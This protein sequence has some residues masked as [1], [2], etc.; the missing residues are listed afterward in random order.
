LPDGK[1]YEGY[2]DDANAFSL[3]FGIT[4]PGPKT[5]A[6]LDALQAGTPA[7]DETLSYFPEILFQYGRC[8][9]AYDLLLHLTSPEFA[10]HRNP[11]TVFVIAGTVATGLM[12]LTP[13]AQANRIDTLSRLPKSVESVGLSRVPILR[14][15]VAVRHRGG[16]E[17]SIT[18]QSGPAFYWKAAFALD[19]AATRRIFVDGHPVESALENRAGVRILASKAIPVEPS[20][21]R[22]AILG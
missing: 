9:A 18:N 4:Q 15:A 22:L 21:T 7:Y 19:A 12:G 14:N 1:Y 20:R 13:D 16:A 17:T 3:R 2:L 8:Q 11:E 5:E 10:S 6:A